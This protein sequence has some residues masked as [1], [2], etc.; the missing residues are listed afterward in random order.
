MTEIIE[1]EDEDE[2]PAAARRRPKSEMTAEK[3]Q[4]AS[5]LPP[6][7]FSEWNS[8]IIPLLRAF[9]GALDNPL[10]NDADVFEAAL[11]SIIERA[12]PEE[13]HTIIRPASGVRPQDC[14]IFT[15]VC[16]IYVLVS[17]LL[18][19]SSRYRLVSPSGLGEAKF[20]KTLSELSTMPCGRTRP[21]SSLSKP[22]LLKL[23]DY[24]PK[25]RG[26]A[27]AARKQSPLKLFEPRNSLLMNTSLLEVPHSIS[28]LTSK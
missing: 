10:D 13:C 18:L 14:K 22:T 15:V 17:G 6:W 16:L 2:V 19:I 8:T 5:S 20:K 1:I 11:Q 3:S 27:H 12:C 25:Q 26:K 7:A 28:S 4:S 21:L 9:Y 23:N 24:K